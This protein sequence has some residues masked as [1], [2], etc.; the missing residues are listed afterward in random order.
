MKLFT[1]P[2]HRWLLILAL[3]AGSMQVHAKPAE[4]IEEEVAVEN[5]ESTE[6]GETTETVG[7]ISEFEEVTESDSEDNDRDRRRSRNDWRRDNPYWGVMTDVTRSAPTAVDARSA[8]SSATKA[9]L[10]A[11]SLIVPMV[12]SPLFGPSLL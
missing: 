8:V 10:V 5:E 12:C 9:S 7:E 4:T 2:F 3:I 1:H 11:I 6:A